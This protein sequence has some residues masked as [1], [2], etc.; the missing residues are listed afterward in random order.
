MNDSNQ[1][2]PLAD[3]NPFDADR[4]LVEGVRREGA[5]AFEERTREVGALAGSAEWIDQG[6][7]ANA[8]PP[9]LRTH[10]R[11]GNR[12]DEVEFHPSWHALLGQAT[13]FG[14][15]AMPWREPRDGAHV[16]RAAQFYLWS[17]VEAGHGCPISM[18]HAAIPP[19][20]KA[21]V[22]AS[23]WEP[24]LLALEYAP[25]LGPIENKRS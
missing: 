1:P 19:L 22:L 8:H 7:A 4:P 2:P 21:P 9:V 18:T 11:F 16:A 6:F 24:K 10:D 3:Y 20:R 5:S 25:R 14:L 15:H 12:L 17:Q 23:I 13:K